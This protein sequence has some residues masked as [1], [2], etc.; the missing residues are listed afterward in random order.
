MQAG[1]FDAVGEDVLDQCA[2]ELWI[3]R[4]AYLDAYKTAIQTRRRPPVWDDVARLVPQRPN[5]GAVVVGP[6]AI[7]LAEAQNPGQ[8]IQ[9]QVRERANPFPIRSL[10]SITQELNAISKVHDCF[11]AAKRS[12]SNLFYHCRGIL[13]RHSTPDVRPISHQYVTKQPV[14]FS[15]V[16]IEGQAKRCCKTIAVEMATAFIGGSLDEVTVDNLTLWYYRTCRFNLSAQDKLECAEATIKYGE[17]LIRRGRRAL[18]LPY[19]EKYA[20]IK[21]NLSV[22]QH[23]L[24]TVRGAWDSC[25]GNTLP[26]KFLATAAYVAGLPYGIFGVRSMRPLKQDF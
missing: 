11:D 23:F 4:K 3:T 7:P 15:S 5:D 22:A 21:R 18:G 14:E 20:T 13:L 9:V 25:P 10:D 2:E 26:A 19:N 1:R 6:V 16:L 17:D 12:N 8:E 24:T